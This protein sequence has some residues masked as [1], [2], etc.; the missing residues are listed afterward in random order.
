M[1]RVAWALGGLITLL[2]VLFVVGAHRRSQAQ[3]TLP[4]WRPNQTLASTLGPEV[5]VEGYG[6]R[7]PGGYERGYAD[8]LGNL[9]P[10]GL[11]MYLWY[12]D[13][14]APNASGLAFNVVRRFN[15]HT[16]AETARYALEAQ[17]KDM[18]DFTCSPVEE[19]QIDGLPFA[20]LY[21]QGTE[22][23]SSG[24]HVTSGFIYAT[25][26]WAKGIIITGHDRVPCAGK[27]CQY[28]PMGQPV[29]PSLE[30]AVLSLHKL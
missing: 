17:K 26:D 16:P 15:L 30:A 5:S 7:L 22:K 6:L 8:L 11:D 3:Q 2:L 28:A 23:G 10:F 1:K 25:N 21:W 19:G 4:V 27:P 13:R 24:L 9:Q 18:D 12:N 29:L 20:R 14:H